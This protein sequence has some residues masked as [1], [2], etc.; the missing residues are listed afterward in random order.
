MRRDKDNQ[1]YNIK[2]NSVMLNDRTVDELIGISK[3]ITADG[4]VNQHE[5]LSATFSLTIP[6]PPVIFKG[7]CFCLTGKFA[8]GPR[9]VCEAEVVQ[10][11]GITKSDVSNLVDYLV[12]GNFCSDQWRHTT[13]GRKIEAA[14]ISLEQM[15]R[16]V[17]EQIAI[18][19]ED[20]WAQYL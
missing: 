12:I 14:I 7:A 1:P 4:V 20:H 3:G 17:G 6:P 5:A 10:R 2:Y 16:Q 15:K 8:Y 11:G 13:Y 19:H 9:K 18:I